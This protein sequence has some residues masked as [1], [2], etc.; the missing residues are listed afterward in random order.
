MY[1]AGEAVDKFGHPMP[2]ET[3]NTCIES[4]A[5]LIGNIGGSK[6]NNVP[7]EKK[8]VKAILKIRKALNLT[9]N[10]RPITLNQN[11]RVFSPLKES[12]ISKVIDI[13]V[14]SD[15]AGSVICGEKN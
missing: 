13:L 1:G 7:L 4:D 3:L 12:I 5:V 15:L 8:P 10:L 14:V 2:K 11:L 6:W 9:S